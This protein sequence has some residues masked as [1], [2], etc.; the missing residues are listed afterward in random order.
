MIPL[1]PVFTSTAA[2]PS[3]PPGPTA[4]ITACPDE[5]PVAKPLES[6]EAT[7]EL[8]LPQVI[9]AP[10]TVIPLEST[11]V[12]VNCCVAPKG[13]RVAPTGDNTTLSAAVVAPVETELLVLVFE[14]VTPPPVEPHPVIIKMP[15]MRKNE[16]IFCRTVP[17]FRITASQLPLYL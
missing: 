2:E 7:A 13:E 9:E 14:P 1:P 6:T 4:V 16:I 12:A 5:T 3:T 15:G 10:V 8:E 17:F 11:T